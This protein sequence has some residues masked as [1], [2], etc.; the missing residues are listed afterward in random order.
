MNHRQLYSQGTDSRSIFASLFSNPVG[1]FSQEGFLYNPR[2]R[3]ET[4]RGLSRQETRT[5]SDYRRDTKHRSSGHGKMASKTVK[6]SE[7]QKKRRSRDAARSRRGQQNDE[8]VELANQLPLPVGL[9][10]QLDRLCIMRLV[11]SYI[12]MKNLLQS[13]ISQDVKKIV[14][15]NLSESSTYEK[16]SLEALDGFVFV[17]T[18]DGQCI[19]VSHNINH[20]MGLSQ[21]EV[22]GNSFYKYIHPCDHE[23]LANQL[24]GQIPLEDM[25]IFDGLFCSDSVFMMS[26][27]LKG[28]SKK[29]I[30]ENPHKS[31]FLRMKSTLTSRGKNVNLRASTYR[32]VHCTGCMKM[33]VK[34]SDTGEEERVPLFMVAIGVPLMFSSTFEVPLDRATFTS[35]HS[36]DM[37]FLSCDDSVSGLLGFAQAEV[38]GK[39]WYHF[40]HA[41]D[42]DTALA[43]HKTLLTK[44]QSVSKYYR[45]LLRTGGWVWLQTKANIVYDSKTCQ[46]QFVLCTNYIIMRADKED[47]IL[48]TEQVNPVP[49]PMGL[50]LVVK[51]EHP[52]PRGTRRKHSIV[53]EER[54]KLLKAAAHEQRQ[55]RDV[56]P[57][58]EAN[59]N[60]CCMKKGPTK[61]VKKTCKCLED[62][63]CEHINFQDCLPVAWDTNEDLIE[64]QEKYDQ[65]LRDHYIQQPT[66]AE[67]SPA[68]NR[69]PFI[70]SPS[71]DRKINDQDKNDDEEENYDERAPFIPLTID[72]ELDGDDPLL[73]EI[74]FIDSP[75]TPSPSSWLLNADESMPSP[76]GVVTSMP[77]PTKVPP[78]YKKVTSLSASSSPVLARKEVPI[79]V[80]RNGYITNELHVASKGKGFFPNIS[81]WDAEVNAPVQ[82]CGLLQGEE[83]L[84]ALDFGD[85]L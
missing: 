33:L 5:S 83:L 44:G 72:S 1:L 48:S 18:P 10:S 70:P 71:E 23:E 29:S 35:R 66:A 51:K 37:N 80:K 49:A 24:G 75:M 56:V 27:H 63:D 13:Y 55:G 73:V 45:F 40:L 34:V 61:I 85:F 46:P 77:A 78:P 39:S 7:F 4:V 30:H 74:P 62:V 79:A 53:L 43:C 76:G 50:N 42:L 20:Y 2:Q 6:N 64:Q 26:N 68:D 9:S 84:R 57:K 69:T 60:N 65:I 16:S 8:F 11:N 14:S 28:G 54:T 17:V 22:T 19:Y 12:K 25:E 67:N 21:I 81:S 32:V 15:L 38:V 47:Y 59:F 36:L 41:C 3:L 31:F 52:E 82:H 58:Q